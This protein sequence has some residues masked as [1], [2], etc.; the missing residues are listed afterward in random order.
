VIEQ[1]IHE[2]FGD[3]E[4]T[5]IGT[6]WW[7]GVLS[8]FCEERMPKAPAPTMRPWIKVRMECIG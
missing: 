4:S 2:V 5:G 3:A 7:S 1:K 8:V 6:G